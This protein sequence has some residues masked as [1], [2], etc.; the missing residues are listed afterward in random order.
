MGSFAPVSL[1][2]ILLCLAGPVLNGLRFGSGTRTVM[3]WNGRR[4][5]RTECME[6]ICR[7]KKLLGTA[8]RGSALLADAED[9][10]RVRASHRMDQG[11]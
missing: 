6:V 10:P 9:P 8:L 4:K 2:A 11:M 5:H 1:V 3:G 7:G